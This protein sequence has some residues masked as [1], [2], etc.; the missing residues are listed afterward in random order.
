M[1]INVLANV[2]VRHILE[3]QVGKKGGRGQPRGEYFPYIINR[4][5]ANRG[6]IASNQPCDWEMVIFKN[7]KVINSIFKQ[8]KLI[9]YNKR[10]MI[11]AYTILIFKFK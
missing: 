11:K 2:A 5:G 8:V 1:G 9:Y 7:I 4:T 3:D 10:L 6:V